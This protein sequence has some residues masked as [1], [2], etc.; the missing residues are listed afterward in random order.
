MNCFEWQSRTSEFLDGSL[1]ASTKK[2]AEAHVSD[3]KECSERHKHY[4]LILSSIAS[5]KRS[6]L[7]VPI[8]KAPLATLIPKFESQSRKS[9]WERAPW[10]VRTS[11]EAFGIAFIV[12]FVVAMVPQIRKL[13]ERSIEQRLDA[14]TMADLIAETEADRNRV[15]SAPLARG[16]VQT[17]SAEA[18]EE[19]EILGEHDDGSN[20]EIPGD[21]IKVG[22]ADIWRFNLKTDSAKDLRG[23]VVQSLI[24]LGVSSDMPGLGGMEAP[25]GIQFDLFLSKGVVAKLRDSL[26]RLSNSGRHNADQNALNENFTWYKS[27]SKK[28]IPAGT[29]R[30]VIWLSQI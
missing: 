6:A 25:G 10:F 21:T 11:V 5:Q 15:A 27:R 3:C 1:P 26:R 24:D 7:P 2:E 23:S 13:Y 28:R 29:A 20:D 12:L 4:R 14:F 30:V 22:D 16:K 9:R 19:D 17:V 8:R 18:S